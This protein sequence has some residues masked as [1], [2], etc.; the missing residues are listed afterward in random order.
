[1]GM[2]DSKRLNLWQSFLVFNRFDYSTII[3]KINIVDIDCD[4][5]IQSIWSFRYELNDYIIGPMAT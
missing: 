2:S 3:A 1:M 4:C 5:I